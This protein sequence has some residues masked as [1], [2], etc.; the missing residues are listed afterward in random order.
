MEPDLYLWVKAAHVAAV[1]IF[2]GGMVAVGVASTILPLL[3]NKAAAASRAIGRW[4][5]CLTIPALAASWALGRKRG[6][7]AADQAAAAIGC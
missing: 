3:E 7:E 6:L 1:L 2:I 5:I 4:N